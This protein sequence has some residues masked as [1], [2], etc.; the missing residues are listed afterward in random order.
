MPL[1]H[2]VRG[3]YEK[4]NAITTD[5]GGSTWTTNSIDGSNYLTGISCPSTTLCV[6]VDLAGNT[7]TTENPAA[8]SGGGAG[9]GATW[10]VQSNIDVDCGSGGSQACALSAISC[11]TT[12]FCAIAGNSGDVATSTDPTDGTTA[13]ATWAHIAHVNSVQLLAMSCVTDMSGTTCAASNSQD[14][15]IST[16]PQAGASGTWPLSH[17]GGAGGVT[18]ATTSL[19]VAVLGQTGSS[20]ATAD[21]TDG[22]SATWSTAPLGPAFDG[23]I[24]H[25][26]CM[27]ATQCLAVGNGFAATGT[28]STT[29]PQYGLGVTL[30]GSGT[31]SVSD[32]ASLTCPGTSCSQEYSAGTQVTLT[33]TPASGSTFNGWSGGG[34]SGTSTTCVVTVNDPT[35]VAAS[36]GLSGPR[37]PQ[38]GNPALFWGSSPVLADRAPPLED[39]SD[40]NS[41]SC[42]SASLCAGVDSR[43]NIITTTNP[44]TTAP[45]SQASPDPS[46]SYVNDIS[47]PATNLCVAVDSNGNV[48]T[49]TDPG[50]GPAALW[51]IEN[52]ASV[53]ALYGISCPSATFCATVDNQHVFV[54][55]DPSDGASAHWADVGSIDTNNFGF[56]DISCPSSKL[57][58][59]VD[60]DGYAWTSTNPTSP[61]SWTGNEIAFLS[62]KA[63]NW[64][65]CT[66]AA[67]LCLAYDNND[68]THWTT[69]PSNPN[70]W[71]FE[72]SID[73]ATYVRDM[74][75]PSSTLCVGADNNGDIVSSTTPTSNGTWTKNTSIE[76]SDNGYLQ[77]ASCP[78]TQLCVVG[79]VGTA[80]S[81]NP[82]S[83]ASATWSADTNAD[84]TNDLLGVSCASS[85]LCVTVGYNGSAASTSD[86]SAGTSATW[87]AKA[88]DGTNRFDAVSCASGP[89]CVAVDDDGN[90]L[91]TATGTTWDSAKS[92]GDG[93]NHLDAVACPS[94]TKCLAV[95]N[96]G[97]VARTGNANAGSPAGSGAT[98]SLQNIDSTRSLNGISCVSATVCV[99]VDGDGHALIT[100]DG[101][102]TWSSQAIDGRNAI[103]AVSCVSSGFC[104][105]VDG[106]G[107][108]AT[109]PDAT[110]GKNTVWTIQSIDGSTSMDAVSCVSASFCAALDGSDVVASK[111]PGTSGSWYQNGIN[112]A[113]ASLDGI[114]CPSSSLCLAVDDYGRVWTGGGTAPSPKHTLSLAAI[115][116]GSGTFSGANVPPCPPCWGSYSPGTSLTIT[117]TPS[118]GSTF[119]GWTGACSGTGTCHVTLNSDQGVSALFNGHSG[120]APKVSVVGTPTSD[121]HGVVVKLHCTASAGQGCQTTETLT[122]VETLKN[123]KVVAVSATPTK[124]AK[125]QRTEPVGT[126]KVNLNAS[127]TTTVTVLLN[128]TGQ[129]LQKQ[130]DKLPVTLTIRL[131]VGSKT[132][133]VAKKTVTI[134]SP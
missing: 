115:G 132:T 74:S 106:D 40:V 118:A 107:N 42:P 96:A 12:S 78:S 112:P 25:V 129:S 24:G 79:G 35:S 64:I 6:G 125:N 7:V 17:S 53:H 39:A 81:A 2:A 99:V 84:G 44:G 5:D 119:A 72:T 43:G 122:T 97:N 111:N 32:G 75:C 68:E 73:T 14:I 16:D 101:G 1:G 26:A 70:S 76:S 90:A 56:D 100:T 110:L 126:K 11:P 98:W 130:F 46:A 51:T 28:A 62:G 21:A 54:S 108:V 31:G 113:A 20:I 88:I 128:S 114:S 80:S 94:A 103:N 117:A 66:P 38:T 60:G 19:C 134:T 124:G 13:T 41:L 69:D 105:A 30:S 34:C 58:V 22:A 67:D 57:C 50:D 55:T 15:Y 123:G 59:A 3:G 65:S 48:V 18:C 61:S 121:G 89:L 10:T 127:K 102:S 85:S 63:L 33:E 91:T 49:S 86:P 95:D 87:T 9:S 133:V 116:T 71:Q 23:R 45:W 104:A 27:S 77:S 37:P 131:T 83:G 8:N 52:V 93:T 36:F 4:G 29:T 47:C 82:D 92:V 109:T 120:P